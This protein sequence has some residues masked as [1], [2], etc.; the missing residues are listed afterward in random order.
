MARVALLFGQPPQACRELAPGS[1][2]DN[3]YA[4]AIN[5]S[6]QVVGEFYDHAD[7]LFHAYVWTQSTGVQDMGSNGA[8]FAINNAGDF[9]GYANGYAALWLDGEIQ[10]LSL[11]VQSH[12]AKFVS[13]ASDINARGQI[14][15][16]SGKATYL[17]TPMTHTALTSS[18]NPSN[19]GQ[20]V[21]FT[22]TVGS[23][24]GA[25]PDGEQIS[26]FV[27]SK[28]LGNAPLVKGLASF[29]TSVLKVGTHSIKASYAGD[30]NFTASK[31][32][33]LK[34]VVQ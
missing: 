6:D 13:F 31:S 11:L 30:A 12:N 4:E 16:S 21:T 27:G 17:L 28:L 24:M 10:N 7:N 3:Y 5:D 9:V 20:P 1:G 14:A 33:A 8:V 29:T 25:P 18:A 19:V 2:L 34:Q 23:I 22:A 32:S 26:F 15:A